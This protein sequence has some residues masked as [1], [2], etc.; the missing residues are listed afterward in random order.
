VAEIAETVVIGVSQDG[1]IEPHAIPWAAGSR[2]KFR[3]PRESSC[4]SACGSY[5]VGRLTLVPH[6]E[7]PAVAKSENELRLSMPSEIRRFP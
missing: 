6:P 7:Q 2:K 4:S 1:R 5:L 3:N